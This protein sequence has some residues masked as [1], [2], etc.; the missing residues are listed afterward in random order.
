[1]K[2]GDFPLG[3]LDSRMAMRAEVERAKREPKLIPVMCVRIFCIG[4]REQPPPI[5][6]AVDPSLAGTDW[7]FWMTAEELAAKQREWDEYQWK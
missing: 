7:Q 4:S 1:M 5:Y 6:T 2:P 3:S